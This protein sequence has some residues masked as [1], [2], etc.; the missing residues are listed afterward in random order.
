MLLFNALFF[1]DTVIV[2]R[3]VNFAATAI[4][5]IVPI[6]L[7]TNRRGV[8]RSRLVIYVFIF[9]PRIHMPVRL[10]NQLGLV[11]SPIEFTVDLFSVITS[12]LR[13][14]E[15]KGPLVPYYCIMQ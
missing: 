11:A 5:I 14:S 3:M 15:A 4:A 12:Q 10:S 9:I 1:L 8:K 7:N 6:I 2:L 13:E